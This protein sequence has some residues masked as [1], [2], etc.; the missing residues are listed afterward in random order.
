MV[1]FVFLRKSIERLGQMRIRNAVISAYVSV[2]KFWCDR[3]SLAYIDKI[4][5]P[6]EWKSTT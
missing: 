1:S 3:R 5:T 6:I 2:F 4:L